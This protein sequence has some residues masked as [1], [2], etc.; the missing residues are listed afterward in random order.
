MEG[1]GFEQNNLKN[2]RGDKIWEGD[3]T[4]NKP[5]IGE[6][7]LGWGMGKWL[8]I[9][10]LEAS[11][12][13][14]LVNVADANICIIDCVMQIG[15]KW[16]LNEKVLK[17]YLQPCTGKDIGWFLLFRYILIYVPICTKQKPHQQN[18]YTSNNN[19]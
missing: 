2:S 1:G 12:E 8:E 16:V 13:G 17:L 18:Y 5:I 4:M 15:Q 3:E 14:Y 19:T 7:M 11:S 10:W 9:I 6:N